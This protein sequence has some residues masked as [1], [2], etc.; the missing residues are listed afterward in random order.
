M[1]K[2]NFGYNY[3]IFMRYNSVSEINLLINMFVFILLLSPQNEGQKRIIKKK[4]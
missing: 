3:D 2:E 1:I 4:R